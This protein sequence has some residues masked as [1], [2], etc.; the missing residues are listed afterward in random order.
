MRHLSGLAGAIL[1]S[2]LL[3]HLLSPYYLIVLSGAL[4][5]AIGCLGLNLLLGNTGL[6]SLGQAA[7]FGVGA[8]TGSFIY[9]FSPITSFEVY[10]ASGVLAATALAAV[11]G[12]LCVR[13]TRIH[14]TILTLAFTQ[15]VHALFIS[16]TIFQPFGGLGKGLFLE[17]GGGLYIPRLTIAGVEFSPDAFNTAIYYVILL[18]FFGCLLLAWR[19]VRSPFGKA[20][21]AIRDNETRAAGVGIRVRRYRWCAFILAGAFAGISGGLFGQVHRQV[22]PEQLGWVFSAKMVLA[23]VLGGTRH[24]LGPALGALAFTAFEEVALRFTLYHSLVLGLLLIAVILALPGGLMGGAVAT[25]KWLR[26]ARL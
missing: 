14:F 23:T 17:G 20:L 25:L 16:G 3:P 5:F 10:L 18:A 12:S 21:N 13:A 26:S 15:M 2:L 19:I 22:T 6:L 24:F 7:Y 9:T 1:L 11:F 8:Y 4:A